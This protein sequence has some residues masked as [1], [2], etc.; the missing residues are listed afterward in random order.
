[1]GERLIQVLFGLMLA[2]FAAAFVTVGGRAMSERHYEGRW[3]SRTNLGPASSQSR[4]AYRFEGADAVC[5]GA[6][7]LGAGLMF[8]GWGV[9][10]I[11]CAC[12]THTARA[13]AA[14]RRWPGVSLCIFLL[15]AQSACLLGLL[16]PWRFGVRPAVTGFYLAAAVIAAASVAY[17]R[18]QWS[19]R[20][21][22]GV[23]VALILAALAL[24]LFSPTAPAGVL[25]AIFAALFYGA[26]VLALY[27][28]IHGPKAATGGL[29]PPASDPVPNPGGAVATPT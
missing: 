11:A 28:A 19:A 24:G 4:G 6:G 21:I 20:L 15:A 10:L 26:H 18:P 12:M 13:A 27:A 22:R 25:L 3:R 5:H 9:A 29:P 23:F 1:M 2:A 17:A 8:G 7:F 16:P 14:A